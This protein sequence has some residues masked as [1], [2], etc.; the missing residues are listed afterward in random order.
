MPSLCWALKVEGHADGEAADRILHAVEGAAAELE[1]AAELAARD[2]VFRQRGDLVAGDVADREARQVGRRLHRRQLKGLLADDQRLAVADRH[3]QRIVGAG[4]DGGLDVLVQLHDELVALVE[5][6][7]RLAL[8][9]R[10]VGADLRIDLGDLLGVGVDQVDVGLDLAVHAV[11]D[12]FQARVDLLEAGRQRFRRGQQGLARRDRGAVAG[13]VLHAGEEVLDRRRQAGGGVG[14][15]VVDLADLGVIGIEGGARGGGRAH[16]LVQEIVAV[17]LDLGDL[18]AGAD[19]TG[20]GLHRGRGRLHHALAAIAFDVGVGDVMAGRRQRGL[21]CE[22]S[23]FTDAEEVSGHV[24]LSSMF[25]LRQYAPKLERYLTSV[26]PVVF[27]LTN[28]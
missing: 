23:A 20:A 6:V 2:G 17:A 8:L 26:M 22:Q 18:G 11:A 3:V 16:L 1:Q 15:Q 14:Q 9:D 7:V 24:F 19:E 21:R 28:S 5:Q 25:L 12:F 4:G 13:H 10:T 27:K